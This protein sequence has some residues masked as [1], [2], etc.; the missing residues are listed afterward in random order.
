MSVGHI[1]LLG[2]QPPDGWADVVRSLPDLVEPGL[3]VNG[4][5]GAEADGPSGSPMGEGSAEPVETQEECARV[6]SPG[7]HRKIRRPAAEGSRSDLED[8]G[9]EESEES[10]QVSAF[11]GVHGRGVGFPFNCA[12]VYFRHQDPEP[13]QA[14]EF[15]RGEVYGPETDV[16][17]SRI[18]P[19]AA[20]EMGPE[21]LSERDRAS[22]V[23]EKGSWV[24]RASVHEGNLVLTPGGGMVGWDGSMFPRSNGVG[25]VPDSYGS[26][27]PIALSRSNST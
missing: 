5:P 12:S 13:I 7:K 25:G 6:P 20:P 9:R 15:R 21:D 17:E 23:D 24:R 11:P 10:D 3:G 4:F 1:R 2:H 8:S 14:P 27:L 19:G 18:D 16:Q 22:L 26:P